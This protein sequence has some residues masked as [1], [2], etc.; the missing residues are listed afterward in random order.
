MV[1]RGRRKSG[2]YGGGGRFPGAAEE[3]P[4]TIGL[5]GENTDRHDISGKYFREIEKIA[6][7]SPEQ[8]RSL[9][10]AI[11]IGSVAAREQFISANLRLVVAIA[12]R[13]YWRCTAAVSSIDLIQEGNIGLIKAVERF[14]PEI[15]FRFSTYATH[16]IRHA[17]ERY[18]KNHAKT[19]RSPAHLQNMRRRY[20]DTVKILREE[21]DRSPSTEEIAMAMGM[22]ASTIE[23]C[24][25]AVHET[26]SLSDWMHGDEEIEMLD[27]I[28]DERFRPDTAFFRKAMA[29]TLSD[30]VLDVVE[31]LPYPQCAIIKLRFGLETDEMLSIDSTASRLGISTDTVRK[32]EGRA[33]NVLRKQLFSMI[34]SL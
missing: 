14:D 31:R 17:I 5:L 7:L 25:I 3:Y 32:Y 30:Q 2:R 1:V 22:K 15:G 27:H 12:K 10:R 28:P 8:E 23:S 9:G 24:Q 34:N 11:K 4:E 6:R 26:L 33:Q 18:L 16:L 13:Y 20:D 21:L 29:R 19:V